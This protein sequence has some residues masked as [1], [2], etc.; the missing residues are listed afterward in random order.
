MSNA[1]DQWDDVIARRHPDAKS[2]DSQPTATADKP[3][4]GAEQIAARVRAEEAR[5][6]AEIV[7]ACNLA[8][9]PERAAGFIRR[10]R[11]DAR[12]RVGDPR[13]VEGPS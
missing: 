13:A 11:Q 5:R 1:T 2:E 6:T 3:T 7:A 9:C 12:R 8:D 10:P 4:E